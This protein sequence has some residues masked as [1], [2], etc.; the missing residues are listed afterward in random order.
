MTRPI[1]DDNFGAW[2]LKNDPTIWN[3]DQFRA[4][5]NTWINNW[6]I[7]RNYRTELLMKPGDLVVFWVSGQSRATPRG[8]LGHRLHNGLP[9]GQLR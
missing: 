9:S 8:Y 7:A 6:S 3:I 1:S 4:D 2:V 5:G